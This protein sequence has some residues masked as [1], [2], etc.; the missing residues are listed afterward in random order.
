MGGKSTFTSAEQAIWNRCWGQKQLGLSNLETYNAV[1][2]LIRH[3]NLLPR[4]LEF[5]DNRVPFSYAA[6]ATYEKNVRS[7]PDGYFGAL[8]LA[9]D[10]EQATGCRAEN[11]G[12]W[13]HALGRQNWSPETLPAV[14]RKNADHHLFAPCFRPPVEILNALE[15]EHLL[16]R[17]R[18]IRF[19]STEFVA[20]FLL[21]FPEW[22]D[23]GRWHALNQFWDKFGQKHLGI[24]AIA[25][26]RL[27]DRRKTGDGFRSSTPEIQSDDSTPIATARELQVATGRR[28]PAA[29]AGLVNY[30]PSAPVQS[31]EQHL[32]QITESL[33]RILSSQPDAD[34]SELAAQRAQVLADIKTRKKAASRMAAYRQ[35]FDHEGSTLHEIVNG[36]YETLHA[37]LPTGEKIFYTFGGVI[38]PV[39][40]PTGK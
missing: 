38:P 16:G 4:I 15:T 37:R 34:V 23:D 17:N 13:A 10:V 36:A 31:D 33:V 12:S 30:Q 35:V 24:K 21:S 5:G 27:T 32:A 19:F 40:V 8:Y 39:E 14:T 26:S 25:L 22:D 2:V 1:D 7:T 28:L 29:A 9:E 6:F 3:V 11:L 18:K 20:F